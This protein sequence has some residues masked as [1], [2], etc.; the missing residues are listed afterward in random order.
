MINN[1]KNFFIETKKQQC[2]YIA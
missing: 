2:E 1:I